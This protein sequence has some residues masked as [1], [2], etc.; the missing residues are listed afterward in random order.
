MK[1]LRM[2]LRHQIF[3]TLITINKEDDESIYD[4]LD[5]LLDVMKYNQLEK[6]E[7]V[8][9]NQYGFELCDSW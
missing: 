6:I 9:S 2:K 8:L 1:P 7:D 4:I 5:L 3:D